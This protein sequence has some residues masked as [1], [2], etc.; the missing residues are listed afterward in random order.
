MVPKRD[1]AHIPLGTANIPD[2]SRQRSN[3]GVLIALLIFLAIGGVSCNIES[4]GTGG[5]PPT[6]GIRFD[7][8]VTDVEPAW[9]PD[10]RT[11]AYVHGDTGNGQTG[12]WLMDTNGTDNRILFAGTD[13]YD[14]TWSPDGHWIAFSN[15]RD[16]FKINLNGDSLTQ[17]TYGAN[18]FEPAW[19]P[20][21]KRIVYDRSVATTL[22]PSGVWLITYS[23]VDAESIAQYGMYPTWY[24]G[25]RKILF[26]M[27]SSDSKGQPLGDSLLSYNIQSS[28]FDAVKFL[29][30]ATFETR[31]PKISP[32]DSKVAFTSASYAGSPQ[33][34]VMNSNGTDLQQLT[35]QQG[36]TCSWSPDGK[37]L[38]YTDSDTTSG[39]LWMMRRDGSQNHPLSY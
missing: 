25:G 13:A 23:G 38:V 15:N 4:P 36:Y 3:A 1:A 39:R 32:D 12:I 10:G 6:I 11:V 21:G 22:G 35:T 20:D 2:G 31:Y 29:S 33:I 26:V 17:L 34:W 9:S 24:P 18:D 37:W 5:S 27:A 8:R 28:S 14:P 7:F 16:I 19:S 30:G